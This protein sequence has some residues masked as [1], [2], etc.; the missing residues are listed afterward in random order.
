MTARS[1]GVLKAATAG[2]VA[3]L[4]AAPR[5]AHAQGASPEWP[6]C[7]GGS[8]ISADAQVA[9]CTAIIESGREAD[10]SLAE[11]LQIRCQVRSQRGDRD[12]AIADCDRAIALKPDYGDAYLKRATAYLNK[13]DNDHAIADYSRAIELKPD[14]WGALTLRGMAYAHKGDY[15]RAIAD[16]TRV[17]ELSPG[18]GMAEG[19]LAEAKAAKA[20]MAGGQALGDPRVWC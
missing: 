10:E 17:L 5:G 8:G 14:S 11:A 13:G 6:Q 16:Y 15:D 2:L 12:A 3:A 1:V 7:W 4:A 9:G 19:G 20:R 18:L